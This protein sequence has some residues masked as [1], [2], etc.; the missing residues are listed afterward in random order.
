MSY[1]EAEAHGEKGH[2]GV[3]PTICEPWKGSHKGLPDLPEHQGKNFRADDIDKHSVKPPK[4][5]GKGHVY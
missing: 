2:A 3:W 5:R 1:V 4:P